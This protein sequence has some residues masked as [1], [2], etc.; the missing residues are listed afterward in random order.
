MQAAFLL[1][2]L[3]PPPA[4][5][6][7]RLAGLD[8]AGAGRAADRDKAFFMQRIDRHVIGG[9]ISGHVVTGEIEQ[10]TGLDQA[11]R[12]VEF[13]EAQMRAMVRLVAALREVG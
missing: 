7:F 10:R 1:F 9:A 5:G 11:A 3:L 12:L 4:P 6:A 13:D 8:R 2:F